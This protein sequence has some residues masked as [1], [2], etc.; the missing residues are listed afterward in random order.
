MTPSNALHVNS[1]HCPS[2]NIDPLFG[3]ALLVST[4]KLNGRWLIFG[5][6]T[7]HHVGHLTG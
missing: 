2:E 4:V 1:C 6:E 7:F 3:T 5:F